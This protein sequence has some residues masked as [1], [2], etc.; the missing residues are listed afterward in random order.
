MPDGSTFDEAALRE[1]LK[2]EL[3]AYKIPKR[4]IALPRAEVPLLSSGKVDLQQ[5]QEAV[6]CL[7]RDRAHHRRAGAVSRRARTATSRW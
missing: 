2:E 7:T 5:L 4:F 1:R 3:S 6:R